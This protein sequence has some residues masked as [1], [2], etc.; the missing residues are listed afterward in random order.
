MSQHLKMESK[1]FQ[2]HYGSWDD[3]TRS[4]EALRFLE[5]YTKKV[6]GGDLS[7]AS[8]DWYAPSNRFY[9]A[10]GTTYEGGDAVWSFMGRLFGIAD[11]IRHDVLEARVISEDSGY[12]VTL[13]TN[14]NFTLKNVADPHLAVPRLLE[15]WIKRSEVT[16]QGTDGLQIFRL[17]VWWDKSSLFQKL[18]TRTA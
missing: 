7:T 5:K 12:V 9:D 2:V 6:D 4:N 14:T 1:P 16:G 17:K 15:F 8:H 3:A 10:D 13:E 18:G 11:A